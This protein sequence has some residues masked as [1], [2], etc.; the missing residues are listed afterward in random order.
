M[1]TLNGGNANVTSS[2]VGGLI[3]VIDESTQVSATVNT[4]RF[5]GSDIIARLGE[6][7]NIAD[8]YVPPVFF[9]PTLR[10]LVDDGSVFQ[11]KSIV[12]KGFSPGKVLVDFMTNDPSGFPITGYNSL[13]LNNVD[14]TFDFGTETL[15]GGNI[16]GPL[17]EPTVVSATLVSGV[18]SIAKSGSIAYYARLWHFK[19]AIASG[20][21]EA[22]IEGRTGYLTASK[23]GDRAFSVTGSPEY[24]WII[25]PVSYGVLTNFTNPANGFAVPFESAEVVSITNA[26]GWVSNYNCYRSTNP[27]AGAIT[28]RVS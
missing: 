15:T 3:T 28:V 8:I 6:T 10:V 9:D 14:V 4:L 12:E 23:N 25:V 17:V 26:Y 18:S 24:L 7:S 2:T 19:S 22:F 5:R 1:R 16:T 11:G 27:T 13:K 20:L 21:T